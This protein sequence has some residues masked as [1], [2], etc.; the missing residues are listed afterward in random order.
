MWMKQLC[1]VGEVEYL[2]TVES[3]RAFSLQIVDA[4]F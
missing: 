1:H 2:P 4:N 3:Y